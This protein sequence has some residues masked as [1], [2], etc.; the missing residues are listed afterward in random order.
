MVGMTQAAAETALTSAGLAIGTVTEA[1]SD[2]IVPGSIISQSPPAGTEAILGSEVSLVVSNSSTPGTG[3]VVDGLGSTGF[4]VS[5]TF[6]IDNQQDMLD[7]TKLTIKAGKVRD[8]VSDS[9]SL[10]GKISAG[11][12]GFIAD[13]A[14]DLAN[15]SFAIYSYVEDEPYGY[16]GLLDSQRIKVDSKRKKISYKNSVSKG[17]FGAITSFKADLSKGTFSVA[18]KNIDLTGLQSPVTVML[19]IGDYIGQGLASDENPDVINGKKTLPILLLAGFTDHLSIEKA[20]KVKFKNDL[21][22]TTVAGSITAQESFIVDLTDKAVTIIWGEKN[23]TILAGSFS[24]KGAKFTCKK[25]SAVEGGVFS[26]TIDFAKCTFKISIKNAPLEVN[27]ETFG[28]A[29]SAFNQ[30]TDIPR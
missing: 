12:L 6:T 7:I 22:S 8:G 27:A 21:A 14:N 11:F 1:Y 5:N 24:D 20:P 30:V 17:Q 16:E 18:A 19:F 23:F 10:T 9:F 26:G 28:L 4:A 15:I 13:P 29:F 25:V 3:D 2:T